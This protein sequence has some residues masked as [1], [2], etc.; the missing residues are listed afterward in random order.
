MKTKVKIT[1]LECPNCA[2][3]LQNEI[4]KIDGVKNVSID[5][6]KNSLTFESETPEKSLDEIKALTKEIEPQAVISTSETR[7]HKKL[8]VD[9]GAL[10]VGIALG[11]LIMFCPMPKWAFW[12]LYAVSALLLGYKTYYKAIKLLFKGVINENLLITISVIGASI[13]TEQMHNQHLE[14]LMVIALYSIGKIFEGLAVDRSRRS[15]EKLA[16]MQP[17]YANVKRGRKEERVNPGEVDLGEIIIVRAGEKV[18]IDG[19]IVKGQALVDYQSLTGESAP[20]TLSKN[21]EILSGGIVL[22]A[23]IQV[24]T[25]SLYQDSAISKIMDLVENASENKSKTETFISK[26]TRWYTLGVVICALLVWAIFWAATGDV[27]SAIYKGLMFLVIS[28]PCAFAIS[29]PLAYF[30]GLGNASKN[31]VLVKGSNFLDACANLNMVAF[32]KTGTLTTG[33]FQIKKITAEKGYKKSEVLFYAALGEQH[34]LHPLAKAI[35][36]SCK[37]KLASVQ[38]VREIAGEG[39]EYSY[40]RAKYFVGRK[41]KTLK[42]TVV[43]VYKND[44]RIGVI[45]LGDTIKQT[46]FAAC[47]GLKKMGIKTA[48]LSGDNIEIVQNVASKLGVDETHAG[49]LPE[50]KFAFLQDCKSKTMKIGYVGDGINDAPSL[51][52][53]NVGFSMGINGAPASI[54]AS[55]VVIVD[56]NPQKILTAIKVARHTRKIVWENIILS[57]LIKVTFLALGTAGITG[58]FVA[59]LA[60]VGVT[61]V[62]ILNSLRALYYRAKS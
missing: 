51:A 42:A 54:E 26:I 49:L 29:V 28:C 27:M 53:A 7:S 15:I 25:T 45:E 35:T 47:S 34:S 4:N 39:V 13:V 23:E 10:F 60:D 2:R 14:G 50:Q 22:D 36:A 41:N 19:K 12:T 46:A 40:H 3:T 18:P 17:E 44:V 6:V 20:I 56:D 48:L 58:M 5:F 11:V 16:R 9:L 8:Y 32:D 59:V 1:G 61:L 31:G 24:R 21:N 43:E 33:E 38:N 62:A 30:A 37:Q 52:L 57:A 55:D